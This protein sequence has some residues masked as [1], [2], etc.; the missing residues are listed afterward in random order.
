MLFTSAIIYSFWKKVKLNIS[1]TTI[2]KCTITRPSLSSMFVFE[3]TAS[4][5]CLVS[6]SADLRL[7]R[8]SITQERES[9]LSPGSPKIIYHRYEEFISWSEVIDRK[10][11]LRPDLKYTLDQLGILD[12]VKTSDIYGD[13]PTYNPFSLTHTRNAEY[14][15]FEDWQLNYNWVYDLTPISDRV[16]LLAESLNTVDEKLYI[17]GVETEYSG[18]KQLY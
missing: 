14:E 1:M 18:F 8:H 12:I 4:E 9:K 13:G 16:A 7:S 2:C 17:D 15:T 10:N 3:F 6:S 11:E 5:F